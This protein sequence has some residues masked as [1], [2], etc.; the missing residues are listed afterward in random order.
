MPNK[1]NKYKTL[2]CKTTKLPCFCFTKKSH[3]SK[4][5][6]PSSYFYKEHYKIKKRKMPSHNMYSL[7]LKKTK[8]I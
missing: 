6:H 8:K 1:K 4:E 2:K 3:E 7:T 5:G